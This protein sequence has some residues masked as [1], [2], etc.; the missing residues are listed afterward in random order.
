MSTHREFDVVVVGA[1][2]GGLTAT[3]ELCKNGLDVLCLEKHNI[4]GGFASSFVRGQ[5]EFEA[6]M[7]VVAEVGSPEDPDVLRKAFRDFGINIDWVKTPEAFHLISEEENI[8]FTMPFGIENAIAAI[9]EYYPGSEQ[10]TRRYLALCK[11]VS[12]A[13]GYF[14]R[15]EGKINK[16]FILKSFPNFVKTAAYSVEQVLDALNTPQQIRNLFQ[17]FWGYLAVPMNKLNWG[18]WALMVYSFLN[19][20]GYIP[21]MRST[22]LSL[23]LQDNIIHTGGLVECNSKVTKI[24]VN[25]RKVWGVETI[26]GERIKC[27]YILSNASPTIVYNNLIRPQSQVPS[28][29]YQ[30]VNSRSTSLS[31]FVVHLGL[32]KSAEEIGFD[33]YSKIIH[34]TSDTSQLNKSFKK[35]NAPDITVSMCLNNIVPKASPEGTSMIHLTTFFDP[36]VW[37]LVTPAMYHQTKTRITQEIIKNFEKSTKML[38]TPY[39]EEVVSSTPATY[40]RYFDSHQGIIYGYGLNSW[41]HTISRAMMA[42]KEDYIDGLSFVGAYALNQAFNSSYVSGINGAKKVHQKLQ[43][44]KDI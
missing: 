39:I 12:D 44:K 17:G 33:S 31:G 10:H 9:E 32:N 42:G 8:D 7:H 37:E 43:E 35:L 22:E 40:A 6:S 19:R 14:G 26:H 5:F 3:A 25:D 2:N 4:P 16:L 28:I 11:E 21:R 23:A 24:I 1:G 36:K 38:L 29:A 13:I 41:D 34:K 15:N 27:N 30:N 18:L 20:G